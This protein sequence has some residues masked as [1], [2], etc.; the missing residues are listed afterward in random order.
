MA[1]RENH[2][3]PEWE[4][5]HGLP[6]TVQFLQPLSACKFLARLISFSKL[7]KLRKRREMVKKNSN[8]DVLALLKHWKNI[9]RKREQNV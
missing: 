1:Q 8:N 4:R 7:S 5:T 3:V 9:P 2:V 6:H